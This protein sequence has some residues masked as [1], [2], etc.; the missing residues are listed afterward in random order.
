MVPLFFNR[1][2][3]PCVAMLINDLI[4]KGLITEKTLL[5]SI[6]IISKFIDNLSDP[7]FESLSTIADR[8]GLPFPDNYG[9][10]NEFVN[11]LHREIYSYD[12]DMLFHSEMPFIMNCNDLAEELNVTLK[13]W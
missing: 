12:F 8:F 9:A 4:N 11:K 13:L 6:S 1:T 2:I 5:S 10:F 3:Y 7:K